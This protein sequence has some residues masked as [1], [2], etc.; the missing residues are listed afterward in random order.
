MQC[1]M[2]VKL[3]LQEKLV[4]VIGLSDNGS[5]L[6]FLSSRFIKKNRLSSLGTWRG[7]VQ[8]LSDT[9]KVQTEFYKISVQTSKGDVAVLALRTDGLGEYFGISYK[10]ALKFAA[11]YGLAPEDILKTSCMQPRNP[12]TCFLGWTPP[13]F[14]LTRLNT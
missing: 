11:H 2:E 14:F 1:C 4:S 10:M 7:S 9:K 13:L 3:N 5:T 6:S 12:S 8:T